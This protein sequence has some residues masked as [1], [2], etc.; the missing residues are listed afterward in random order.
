MVFADPPYAETNGTGFIHTYK[1]S[2]VRNG[3][4]A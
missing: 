3:E 2:G 1:L 4:A